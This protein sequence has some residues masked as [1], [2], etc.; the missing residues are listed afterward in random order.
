MSL[1]H[2][3]SLGSHY[4]SFCGSKRFLIIIRKLPWDIQTYIIISMQTVMIFTAS[5]FSNCFNI[6]FISEIIY[7]VYTDIY[8]R[9]IYNLSIFRPDS[10]ELFFWKNSNFPFN[11][12]FN[13]TAPFLTFTDCLF[14]FMFLHVYFYRFI[15]QST[16]H[17]VQ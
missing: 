8:F 6:I 11:K 12:C 17:I 9:S 5:V 2:A 4:D 1:L 10:I 7:F 15:I 3:M 14:I 13:Q 16:L